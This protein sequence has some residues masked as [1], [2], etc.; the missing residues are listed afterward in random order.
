MLKVMSC[1]LKE[2]NGRFFILKRRHLHVNNNRDLQTLK[3]FASLPICSHKTQLTL[4]FTFARDPFLFFFFSLFYFRTQPGLVLDLHEPLLVQ[5]KV[6]F[7][8]MFCNKWGLS[9][10]LPHAGINLIIPLKEQKN[11]EY[12]LLLTLL[13]I[14][15]HWDSFRDFKWSLSW[16]TLTNF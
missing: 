3:T 8:W 16:F 13:S 2:R 11:S 10:L 1:D 4:F 12:V 7:P 14:R 5:I 6:N 15:E 9:S